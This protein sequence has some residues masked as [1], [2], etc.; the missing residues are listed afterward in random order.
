MHDVAAAVL[1]TATSHAAASALT[2]GT[3]IGAPAGYRTRPRGATRKYAREW[4]RDA[5]PRRR[6]PLFN[7][8]IRPRVFADAKARTWFKHNVEEVRNFQ[9]FLPELYARH[10]SSAETR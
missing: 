3:R 9:F 10:A 8:V 7:R 5:H 2:R 4:H 6:A 1:V